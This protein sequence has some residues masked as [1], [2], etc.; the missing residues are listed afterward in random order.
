MSLSPQDED[1][2]GWC[3]LDPWP[4]WAAEPLVRLQQIVA[5]MAGARQGPWLRW[6]PLLTPDP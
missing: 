2:E 1:N 4:A 6:P 5:A 3:T